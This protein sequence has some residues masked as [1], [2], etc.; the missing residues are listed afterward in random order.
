LDRAALIAEIEAAFAGST[1]DPEQSL[2]QSQL[3]DQSMSRRIHGGE[4]REAG[5]RDPE[6][7]WREVPGDALDECDAALAHFTPESW[8]FY[9]PAYLSRSLAQFSAPRH[10]TTMLHMVLFHLTC[11]KKYDLG[12]RSY[13]LARYQLLTPAQHQA[14]RHFLELVMQESLHL[15]ETTNDYY[16]TYADAQTALESYWQGDGL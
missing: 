15:V 6:L 1:R 16:Q 2:H 3:T 8:R 4:W 10:E 12:M 9:L 5:R 7:D 14:V 11:D 13:V